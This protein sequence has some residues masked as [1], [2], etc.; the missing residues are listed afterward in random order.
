[1]CKQT[2]QT[3]LAAAVCYQLASKLNKLNWQQQFVTSAQAK[4]FLSQ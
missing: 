4:R 2:E 3:E 1:V